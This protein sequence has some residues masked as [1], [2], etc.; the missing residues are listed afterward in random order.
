MDNSSAKRATLLMRMV[1][2]VTVTLGGDEV[3]LV[4]DSTDFL[5]AESRTSLVTK[6]VSFR[7]GSKSCY[8]GQPVG[9]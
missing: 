9:S 6:N 1:P 8:I 5:S 7:D 4:T 3:N 2:Q